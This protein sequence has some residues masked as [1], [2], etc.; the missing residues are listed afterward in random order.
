MPKS[1]F[2]TFPS[3][4]HRSMVYLAYQDLLVGFLVQEHFAVHFNDALSDKD[5]RLHL[6]REN[7]KL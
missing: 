3:L 2:G 7:Q 5:D 4:A 1:L 6:R